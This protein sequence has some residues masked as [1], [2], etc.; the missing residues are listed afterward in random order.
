MFLKRIKIEL[1]HFLSLTQNSQKLIISYAFFNSA[2]PILGIFVNAYLWRYSQSIYLV[3]LY[4]FCMAIGLTIGFYINGKLLNNIKIN[5]LYLI[6]CILQGVI[7]FALMFLSIIN[8][9][10]VLIFGF[11]FGIGSSFFW[12]NKHF[13]TV[14][15]TLH[16]QRFYFNNLESSISTIISIIIPI[17]IGW[18]IAYGTISNLYSTNYAYVIISLVAFVLLL[19]AGLSIKN[20]NIDFYRIPNIFL[21]TRSYRWNLL[22]IITFLVGISDGIILFIPTLIILIL[23]GEENVLGLFQ[24]LTSLLSA[25]VVYYVARKISMNNRFY[26]LVVGV[27]FLLIG[28][29]LFGIWFGQLSAIVYICLNTFSNPLIWNPLS[30]ITFELIEKEEKIHHDHKY[31]YIF[32]IELFL[33]LGRYIGILLFVSIMSVWN[34]TSALQFSPFIISLVLLPMTAL[35]RLIEEKNKTS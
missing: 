16:K 6:G 23:L 19:G 26:V 13:L 8:T 9:Q 15:Q 34:K 33:N 28:T 12:A 20:I 29:L 1:I 30:N 10:I 2:S 31:T 35:F 18:F 17:V 24:S 25:G 27:I 32:D 14:S 5:S 3:S 4:N 7:I 22:R 11:V 21:K